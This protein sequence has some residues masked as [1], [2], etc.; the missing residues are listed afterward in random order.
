MPTKI[1]HLPI[2]IISFCLVISLVLLLTACQNIP[3]KQQHQAHPLID[4]IWSV[5][6]QAFISRGKLNSQLKTNNIILLGETHDNAK[7]HQ[8]QAEITNQLSQQRPKVAFE[9][10]DQNQQ[11]II[12]TFQKK[13]SITDDFAKVVNW[14]KTGW[15]QWSY[16]RPVFD[17]AIS[18]NLEI[19]AA[20][21]NSK[22][23]RKVIKYGTKVLTPEYQTLLKRYQYD[24][25]TKTE[26]E[27]D[28]RSAHCNMLPQKMLAPMLLGQQSRDIAMTLAIKNNFTPPAVSIILIAGT[29][30]TRTDF[31]IP[32]YLQQEIPDAKILSLAFI[33]IS[34]DKLMATEYAEDWSINGKNLPFDY[35]WFTNRAER[36]DQCEK[37][38]AYMKKKVRK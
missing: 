26:L 20:N 38:R 28:I 13:S 17:S 18:N 8:L 12:N 3:I 6:E 16:Y 19:I 27:Q 34:E 37:M 7:H 2:K 23:V 32:Y 11:A 4:R 30:H 9:M 35:V 14:E 24:A 36:E 21:I 31:G 10:L 29:G 1:I 25:D 33:E 5:S 15:P 22:Q